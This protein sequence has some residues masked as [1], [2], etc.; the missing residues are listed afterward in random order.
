VS[1]R[2]AI[3]TGAGSGIGRATAAQLLAGGHAV[4][5]VD[6]DPGSLT[7]LSEHPRGLAFAGDIA[8]AET[9]SAMV[10]LALERFGG[11]DVVVL[12]AG[13]APIGALR[14]LTVEQIDRVL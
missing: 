13:I 1:H 5:G 14:K 2:V 4:V 3:V 12:N 6:V 8:G 10:E 9:N 11:V 7:W